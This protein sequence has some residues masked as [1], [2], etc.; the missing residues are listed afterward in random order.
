MASGFI[1][2]T[3]LDFDDRFIKGKG[4]QE[5]GL[6]TMAGVDVGLV[7]LKGDSGVTTGYLEQTGKDVGFLLG[8]NAF[9]IR[10][11][12]RMQV[13]GDRH[14]GEAEAAGWS[15]LE[16]NDFKTDKYVDCPANETIHMGGSYK[17]TYYMCFRI[18]CALDDPNLKISVDFKYISG[19]SARI[20][21]SEI[22]HVSRQ[23]VEF[24]VNAG[25]GDKGKR[26][27]SDLRIVLEIPGLVR[28][29]CYVYFWNRTD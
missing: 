2:R 11:T 3:G 9:T 12:G 29:E 20:L 19:S 13:N 18:H 21:C 24:V 26:G 28:K 7:Y 1:D 22:R 15:F 25:G 16:A 8:D 6:S 27:S 17:R 4:T 10:R 14:R 23:T 5:F